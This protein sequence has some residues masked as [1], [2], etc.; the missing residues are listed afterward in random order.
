MTSDLPQ[1]LLT[2]QHSHIPDYQ[3]PEQ[4]F[5][6]VTTQMAEP[7]TPSS[8]CADECS[9]STTSSNPSSTPFTVP[10]ASQQSPESPSPA[11]PAL[12]PLERIEVLS[13]SCPEDY[14]ATIIFGSH[15]A[16]LREDIKAMPDAYVVVDGGCLDNARTSPDAPG[17]KEGQVRAFS[18]IICL[19]PPSV[20]SPESLPNTLR[21]FRAYLAP[22]GTVLVKIPTHER[23]PVHRAVKY[24]QQVVVD[25]GVAANSAD[26]TLQEINGIYLEDSFGPPSWPEIN[27]AIARIQYIQQRQSCHRINAALLVL[28][29]RYQQLKQ[30]IKRAGVLE[31]DTLSI[32]R[33]HLGTQHRLFATLRQGVDVCTESVSNTTSKPNGSFN[34]KPWYGLL[35]PPPRLDQQPVQRK[36]G[37]E[38]SNSGSRLQSLSRQAEQQVKDEPLAET[39]Q[40]GMQIVPDKC[41]HA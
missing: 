33:L 22:G 30:Q 19:G 15:S 14:S 21:F 20:I 35:P 27:T 3:T 9:R 36:E 37:S 29:S 32:V 16:L 7:R 17:P 24:S 6:T 2:G 23:Q 1:L 25:Y 11:V 5:S 10:T 41:R 40:V 28:H 8:S 12:S 18:R 31:G 38:D 26:M 39:E 34:G 13:F 4:V